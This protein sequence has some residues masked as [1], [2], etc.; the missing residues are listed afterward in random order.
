MLMTTGTYSPK[1]VKVVPSSESPSRV[2][3]L[4]LYNLRLENSTMREICS[5]ND[6]RVQQYAQRGA[7]VMYASRTMLPTLAFSLSH[8]SVLSA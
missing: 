8:H 4:A 3:K 7:D 2:G 1:R 5:P 6:R